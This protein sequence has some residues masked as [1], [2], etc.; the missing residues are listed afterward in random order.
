MNYIIEKHDTEQ[1][2]RGYV[3]RADATAKVPGLWLTYDINEAVAFSSKAAA[4]KY[5]GCLLGNRD[6]VVLAA[7]PTLKTA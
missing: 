5:M 1:G 4:K 6:Q 7:V 2:F 3:K